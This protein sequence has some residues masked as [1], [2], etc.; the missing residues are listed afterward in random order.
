[1][2]FFFYCCSERVVRFRVAHANRLHTIFVVIIIIIIIIPFFAPRPTTAGYTYRY[3][4]L[5]RFRPDRCADSSGPAGVCSWSEPP[6]PG[7]GPTPRRS[8]YGTTQ[9]NSIIIIL[10]LF[11]G[12]LQLPLPRHG[13]RRWLFHNNIY[14]IIYIDMK[15]LYGFITYYYNN[16]IKENRWRANCNR[17]V[18]RSRPLVYVIIIIIYCAR[19]IIILFC[20]MHLRVL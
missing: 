12:K 8:C 17:C 2:Q 6:P 5:A 7:R 4:Q 19:Y 20:I 1:M 3:W 16:N 18:R 11:R 14:N 15:I 9:P 10:L 13:V